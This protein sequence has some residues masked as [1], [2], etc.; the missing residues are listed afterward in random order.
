MISFWLWFALVCGFLSVLL[1]VVG[2]TLHQ[3]RK[4]W[5]TKNLP[6]V[7]ALKMADEMSRRRT[8]DSDQHVAAHP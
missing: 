4:R 1:I 8:T 6:C 3:R 2:W 7:R 5:A